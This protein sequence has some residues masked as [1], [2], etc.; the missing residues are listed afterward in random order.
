[1]FYFG[2]VVGAAVG[3]IVGVVYYKW[4][5]PRLKKLWMKV[6]AGVRK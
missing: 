4:L 3:V 2:L 1:M 6:E 5:H